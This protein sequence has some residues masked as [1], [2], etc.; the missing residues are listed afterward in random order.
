MNEV[1]VVQDL[2][3]KI[4]RREI[5]RTKWSWENN[6]HS[7]ADV[8][9]ETNIRRDLFKWIRCD[10]K[11]KRSTKAFRCHC[12]VPYFLFSYELIRSFNEF[13]IIDSQSILSKASEKSI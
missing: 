4:R 2:S 7:N 3:K 10:K 8:A 1:L 5:Y 13:S 9:C 11:S 6:D 12:R